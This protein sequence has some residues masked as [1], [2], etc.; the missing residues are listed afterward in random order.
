MNIPKKIT[1]C[2]QLIEVKF[3]KP[4]ELD[5]EES[6]G[7]LNRNKNIIY[8]NENL[9]QTQKELTFIHELF[10]AINFELDETL[11]ESLAQQWY[12]VLKE[13]KMI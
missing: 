12:S 2:G 13:N 4:S 9:C 11:V 3:V 5:D 10:H 8:I 7:M 1:V 6:C